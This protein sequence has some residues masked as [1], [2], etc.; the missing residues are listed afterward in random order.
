MDPTLKPFPLLCKTILIAFYFALVLPSSEPLSTNS[1][2]LVYKKCADQRPVGSTKS[3]SQTLSSLFQELVSHSSQSKFFKTYE[4]G[5]AGDD[6]TA[7]FGLFQCRG[8]ISNEDCQ[9][10]VKTL[11]DASTSLCKEALAARVQLQGCYIRYE[12]DG[13]LSEVSDYQFLHKNCEGSHD[14][15]GG[16]EEMRDAAFSAIEKAVAEEEEAGF[17]GKIKYELVE[18]MAQCEEDMGACECGQCVSKAVEIAQEECGGAFSGEIYMDK[19]F[20]SY[21][22]NSH[23]DHEH[24]EKNNNSNGKAMAIILG[25]AAAL[26]FGFIFLLFFRSCTKKGDDDLV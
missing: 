4:G 2:S 25:G 3:H 17:Y 5:G 15:I 12:P 13:V 24:K 14:L 11:P 20:L 18:V 1:S 16:F 26:G 21:S 22:Y 19:C 7:F 6:Q 9:N 8:D 23:P 10:C